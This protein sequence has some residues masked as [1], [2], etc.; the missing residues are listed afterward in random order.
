MSVWQLLF[1][2]AAW[3]ADWTKRLL[4]ARGLSSRTSPEDLH[5][6]FPGA[7]EIVIKQDV[8]IVG[9]QLQKAMNRGDDG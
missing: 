6:V 3:P 5:S 4:L 1:A 2:A 9:K 7:E 8:S